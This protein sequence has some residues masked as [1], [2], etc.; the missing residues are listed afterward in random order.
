MGLDLG[1]VD[2][3]AR[4]LAMVRKGGARVSLEL[5]EPTAAAIAVWVERRGTQAGALFVELMRRRGERQ[6]LA[7]GG[8]YFIVR[9][10]GEELGLS[11]RPHGLRHASITS[12]LTLAAER[13]VPL[14]EVLAATGHARGSVGV[15]VGYFDL[16]MSRQGDLARL[17]A[18]TVAN[19]SRGVER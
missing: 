6:R 2:L 18:G 16:G 11:V 8:V 9:R 14:S 12:V 7:A 17:V 4:R 15:V 13:G 10:L 1:D 3:K 19:P 5:P